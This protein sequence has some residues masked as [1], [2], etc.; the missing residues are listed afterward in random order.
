MGNG[1]CGEKGDVGGVLDDCLDQE[2]HPNF[3]LGE[4]PI[5]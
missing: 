3:P 4:Y 2:L 1:H 5:R